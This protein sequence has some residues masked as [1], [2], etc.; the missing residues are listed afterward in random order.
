MPQN[1]F[2]IPEQLRQVAEKNVEQ[3]T[4]AYHQLM[5]S[6][7]NATGMWMNTMPANNAT[8]GFKPVQDMAEKFAKDSAEA[9]LALAKDI[10]QAKDVQA[11]FTLQSQFAQTQM[12]AYAFQAQELGR[13]MT[14]ATQNSMKG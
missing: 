3:A 12:R 8:P 4:A 14:E 10:A 5:E 11:V 6:M 2:E 13:L 1:P 9:C 7:T